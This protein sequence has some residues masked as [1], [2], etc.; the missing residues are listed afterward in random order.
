MTVAGVAPI[1][2]AIVVVVRGVSVSTGAGS[3]VSIGYVL[4]SGLY[5]AVTILDA[6][7]VALTVARAGGSS[8]TSPYVTCND[9]GMTWVSLA[10]WMAVIRVAA[11]SV[12][13]GAGVV[14]VCTNLAMESRI[15]LPGASTSVKSASSGG[16]P[17]IVC[18][19]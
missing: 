1:L 9:L 19:S 16:S 2:L 18:I 8:V 14:P 10:P 17:S 4:L 3:F 15:I 7:Y 13:L 11:S 5:G 12:T 6:A